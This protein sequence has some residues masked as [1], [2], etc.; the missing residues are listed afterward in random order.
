MCTFCIVGGRRTST[1]VY[2]YR[3]TDV[4]T[5]DGK[6]TEAVA[7]IIAVGVVFAS[8]YPTVNSFLS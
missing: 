4:A 2:C 8:S 5:C 3:W 7:F 1:N 6:P